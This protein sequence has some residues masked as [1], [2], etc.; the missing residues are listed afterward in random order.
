MK[1]TNRYEKIFE[2]SSDKSHLTMWKPIPPKNYKCVGFISLANGVDP[3]GVLKTP[4]LHKKHCRKPLN[5]GDKYF[6]KIQ[7]NKD[8]IFTFWK[9]TPPS[10]YGCLSNVVISGTNEPEQTDLIYCVSLDYL[11]SNPYSRNMI[12]NNLPNTH[13][14]IS[15]W[16][17]KNDFF[18]AS[19]T[20]NHPTT[21]DFNLDMNFI[22]VDKD[23][24]D[25]SKDIIMY[26]K[27]NVNNTDVYDEIDRENLLKKTLAGRFDI[28]PKR[29]TD[30]HVNENK[31]EIRLTIQN[32]ELNSGETT[33]NE[34]INRITNILEKEEIKIYN[35]NKNNYI[36]KITGINVDYRNL[37]D[38]NHVPLDTSSF[39]ESIN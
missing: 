18:H 30:I 21:M 25:L 39:L 2:K 36:S 4:V 23:V 34:L 29:L 22:K 20:L 31:K 38:I 14:M 32:R 35:K 6:G 26:Y 10:G 24:M 5:Y 8:K 33:V 13:N 27:I 19:V 37:K 1:L 3:N 28:D 12:W 7:D 9:P 15:I 11:K 16:T 17:N